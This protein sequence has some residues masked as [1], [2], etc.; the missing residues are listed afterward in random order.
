MELKHYVNGVLG[1][2]NIDNTLSSCL[3][4]MPERHDDEVRKSFGKGA[5][6]FNRGGNP[7]I[8]HS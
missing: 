3:C 8:K 2:Q 1:K 4:P 6:A 5:Y 7:Q